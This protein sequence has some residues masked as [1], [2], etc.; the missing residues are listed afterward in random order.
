VAP[1]A[2][3]AAALFYDR[4]FSIDPALRKHVRLDM[5]QLRAES[6][7]MIGAAVRGL[8]D[9]PKLVPVLRG[10]GAQHG[11]YGVRPRDYDSVAQALM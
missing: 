10:L 3:Q 8:H 7:Q 11:G 2:D 9:L 1:I 4:L 5:K 6:I